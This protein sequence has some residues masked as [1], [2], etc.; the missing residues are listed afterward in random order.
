MAPLYGAHSRQVS[1]DPQGQGDPLRLQGERGDPGRVQVE[2]AAR[3]LLA[4]PDS[5][6]NTPEMCIEPIRDQRGVSFPSG[7]RMANAFAHNEP[8]WHVRAS[9]TLDEPARLLHRYGF[10]LVS[11]NQDRWRVVRSDMRHRRK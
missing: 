10:V 3:L 7:I 1:N 9:E 11:V 2:E 8:G 6:P 4:G 5:L